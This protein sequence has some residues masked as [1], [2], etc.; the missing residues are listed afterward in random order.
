MPLR[1][2]KIINSRGNRVY[3]LLMEEILDVCPDNRIKD[4]KFFS[5][6]FNRASIFRLSECG[7]HRSDTPRADTACHLAPWAPWAAWLWARYTGAWASGLAVAHEVP[8]PPLAPIPAP[9]VELGTPT[10]P[11]CAGC[12]AW[13]ASCHAPTLLCLL[14]L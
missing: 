3:F 10:L 2:R 9:R 13:T 11:P 14:V 8:L 4:I 5:G 12:S 7:G 1:P 6:M